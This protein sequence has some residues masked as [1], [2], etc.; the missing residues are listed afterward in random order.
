MRGLEW[1]S[2]LGRVLELF[3]LIWEKESEGLTEALGMLVKDR[4]V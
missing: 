4:V 1:R 2:G 3:D